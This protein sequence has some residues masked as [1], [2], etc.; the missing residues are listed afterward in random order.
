LARIE[1]VHG[2]DIVA[3]FGALL[4]R[5][6]AMPYDPQNPG[7]FRDI[8]RRLA[9]EQFLSSETIIHR[10]HGYRK[11]KND[12]TLPFFD[13]TRSALDRFKQGKR[14]KNVQGL[15]EIYQFLENDPSY[16]YAFKTP[17][18]P[19]DLGVALTQFF[20]EGGQ[21]LTYDLKVLGS[22]LVRAYTLYCPFWPPSALPGKARASLMEIARAGSEFKITE[23][24]NYGDYQ[25]H[26]SGA[27]FSFG[28]F[29]YFLL[30][31]DSPG[32]A[33]LA[34]SLSHDLIYKLAC[35]TQENNNGKPPWPGATMCELR[36]GRI[37]RQ[38]LLR[39]SI[40]FPIGIRVTTSHSPTISRCGNGHPKKFGAMF[41]DNCAVLTI[42]SA[43]SFLKSSWWQKPPHCALDSD[44]IRC[45][46]LLLATIEI[47]VKLH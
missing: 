2:W 24:Q 33:V 5:R 9:D 32:T 26:D 23:T 17:R 46:H 28:K 27:L 41:I 42:S 47:Q 4:R 20:S 31:E 10:V 6:I 19:I 21:H 8:L 15:Q 25:Q 38:S 29:I 3:Q 37:L 44:Q 30:K 1:C 11:A 39:F 22:K 12:K 16:S 43:L 36:P 34:F 14:I 35:R 13:I 40:C 7:A 18:P 45:R